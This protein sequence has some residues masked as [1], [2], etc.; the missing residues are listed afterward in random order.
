M[1][2]LPTEQRWRP[3]VTQTKFKTNVNKLHSNIDNIYIHKNIMNVGEI[4]V[5]NTRASV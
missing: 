3:D 4:T 2:E 1:M 5:S